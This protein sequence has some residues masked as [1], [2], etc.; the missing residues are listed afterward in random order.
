MN[1]QARIF[2]STLVSVSKGDTWKGAFLQETRSQK[3]VYWCRLGRIRKGTSAYCPFVWGNLVTWKSKKQPVVAR[4]ST[5]TELRS[6]VHGVCEA[7]WLRMLLEELKMNTRMSLKLLCDNRAA[8]NICHSPVHNDRTKH[9][10]VNHILLKIRLMKNNQHN[11]CPSI[12]AQCGCPNGRPTQTMFKK[13]VD[14]LGCIT[15]TFQ[16]EGSVDKIVRINSWFISLF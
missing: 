10:E 1:K 13:M 3:H 8:I 2:H 16:C 14:K 4:S 11:V 5:E 12:G 6:L 9:I 15:W 7:L